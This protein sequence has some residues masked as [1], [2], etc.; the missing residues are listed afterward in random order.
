MKEI[1]DRLKEYRERTGRDL[2]LRQVL[3]FEVMATRWH[4]DLL[5]QD[6]LFLLSIPLPNFDFTSSPHIFLP[7]TFSSLHTSGYLKSRTLILIIF[8]SFFRSNPP[9]IFNQGEGGGNFDKL[10]TDFKVTKVEIKSIL[11]IST[12]KRTLVSR[13][14][15]RLWERKS[16]LI[17]VS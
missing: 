8:V 14:R 16:K 5:F 12:R 17:L 3:I 4:Q 15:R 11:I 6:P 13:C 1:R 2:D 10:Y 7:N 9:A